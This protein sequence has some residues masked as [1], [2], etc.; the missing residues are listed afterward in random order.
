MQLGKDVF[1]QCCDV[2]D[3]QSH[4]LRVE[5]FLTRLRNV[6]SV[7]DLAKMLECKHA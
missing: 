2:A 6:I 5:R 4:T 3:V 7:L 1:I